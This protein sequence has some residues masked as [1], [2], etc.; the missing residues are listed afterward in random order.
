MATPKSNSTLSKLLYIGLTP[1][2]VK[3]FE[4][5]L[6][7]GPLTA[8]VI[9][10]NTHLKK[11]D[12]Y[13]KLY[14]LKDR[15]LVEEFSQAK[16]KHFRLSNPKELEELVAAQYHHALTAKSEIES[17]LPEII[18]TYTLNYNKP[19]TRFY[20]GMEAMQRILDESF[21]T[22]DEIL[23][24]TDSESF[25]QYLPEE[26]SKYVQ[27]RLR[28]K[29]KKRMLIPD[30]PVNRKFYK[31]Q[32]AAYHKYTQIR[33]IKPKEARFKTSQLIYNNSI[34]FQTLQP[35]SMIGVIIE[36][37]QICLMQR[38]LF[39]LVWSQAENLN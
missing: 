22:E 19:V 32:S 25:D 23:Q 16:K 7:L 29:I 10:Q 38:Q 18:S 2:E 12:C 39:E 33:F 28:L 21:T 20:E 15:G 31:I 5:L 3:I 17:I 24:I 34:S 36:D 27:K 13:K 6:E 37:P 8:A 35:D 11:G 14:T 1:G 9:I 4:T 26:D 30:S